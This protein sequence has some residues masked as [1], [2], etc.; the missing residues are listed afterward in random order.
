MKVKLKEI[1]DLNSGYQGK[2]IP[3]DSYRQIKLVNVSKEGILDYSG[4]ETFDAEKV[5]EKYL[6]RREDIIIK[7]KSGDHTA[8]LIEEET[9]SL[10]AT[11]HFIL[12]R[13]KEGWKEKISPEYLVMYL[14]SQEAQDYL[15]RHS[16]GT[17][18]PIIKI[19]TLEE[20]EIPVP[21]E[22]VQNKL[23][24]LYGLMLEEKR[25]MQSIMVQREKQ[26]TAQ[27]RK[28]LEEIE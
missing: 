6:L 26:L 19:S 18:L 23:S 16:T 12:M 20:M 17:V 11:A 10:V 24:R 1:V 9:D 4:L 27:L 28:M 22:E 15:T 2:T 5:A 8:A 25:L 3:G 7:A 14:N 13:L 21:K